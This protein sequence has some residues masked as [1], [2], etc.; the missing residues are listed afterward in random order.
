MRCIMKAAKVLKISS[1]FLEVGDFFRPWLL[2]LINFHNVLVID[3]VLHLVFVVI[4]SRTIS[5]LD[6]NG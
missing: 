4:F 1:F 6:N 3:K 5:K 2:C